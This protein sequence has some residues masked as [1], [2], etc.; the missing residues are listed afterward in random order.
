M[1]IQLPDSNLIDSVKMQYKVKQKIENRNKVVL[2][3]LDSLIIKMEQNNKFLDNL[4]TN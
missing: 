4:I 1:L 2:S 3:K